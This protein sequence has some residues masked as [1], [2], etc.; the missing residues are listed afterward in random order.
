MGRGTRDGGQSAF[1]SWRVIQEEAVLAVVLCALIARIDEKERERVCV[2]VFTS[3]SS[4]C[5]GVQANVCPGKVGSVTER[6]PRKRRERERG[7][8]KEAEMCTATK[9]EECVQRMNTAKRGEKN[10]ERGKRGDEN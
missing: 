1:F 3:S 6:K 9:R 10:K 7:R 5:V 8:R 4:Q 2:C